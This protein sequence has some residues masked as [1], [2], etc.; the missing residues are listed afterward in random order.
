MRKSRSVIFLITICIF[1]MILSGC[2]KSGNDTLSPASS[3]DVSA[4]AST[5]ESVTQESSAEAVSEEM[6][7]MPNPLVEVENADAFEKELGIVFNKEYLP[8]PSESK[9]VIISKEM[10]QITY[11]V[12]NVNGDEAEV[13]LRATKSAEP[14]DISGVYDDNM[15]VYEMN[16]YNIDFVHRISNANDYDIY[17]FQKDDVRY[18]LMIHGELSQMTIGA[19]MD[20][21][22]LSCG[23]E[24]GEQ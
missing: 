11:A 24:I 7:G 13:T 4:V 10:A 2:T 8:D 12:E 5:S 17:E 18:C 14:E 20:Q 16:V 22:V 1:I 3:T 19:I 15:E 9:Y 23:F 21:T 6:V